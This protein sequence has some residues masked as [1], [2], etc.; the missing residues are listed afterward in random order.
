M[1][2]YKFFIMRWN[3]K[4]FRIVAFFLL[5][6]FITYFLSGVKGNNFFIGRKRKFIFYLVEYLQYWVIRKI[7]YFFILSTQSLVHKKIFI[8][9]LRNFTKKWIQITNFQSCKI[10]LKKEISS[11]SKF[12]E[13]IPYFVSGF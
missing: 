7:F 8:F 9:L 1:H 5:E 13:I 2:F 6:I 12:V 10:C 4:S 3:L 11:H